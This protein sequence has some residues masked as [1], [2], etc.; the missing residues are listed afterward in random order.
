MTTL[1][2]QPNFCGLLV[3]GL[4]GLHCTNVHVHALYYKLL[5][6]SPDPP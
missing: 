2:I 4:T 1:L 5:I 6:P 3:T